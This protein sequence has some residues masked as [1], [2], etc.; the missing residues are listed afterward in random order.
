MEKRIDL[1]Q[2][3]AT[4]MSQYGEEGIIRAIF[5]EI[6]TRNKVCVEFGAFALKEVSNVYPLWFSEGWTALLLEADAKRYR[7]MVSDYEQVKSECAGRAIIVRR[8][9]STSGKDALDKILAEYDMPLDLDLLCIDV[10]GMDY[11]IWK[12]LQNF[13]PRV[14]MLEFNP[15]IP[16]DIDLVGAESGNYLGSSARAMARLG[17]E[18]G[19]GLVACTLVNAIFVREEY[20]DRFANANDLKALFDP[21]CISYAMQSFDGGVFFSG[22][23]FPFRCDPF[24]S[25]SRRIGSSS[26]PVRAMPNMA[27][28]WARHWLK[29]VK[30]MVV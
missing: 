25:E 13:R 6:G 2:C 19:Y 16:P 5:H 23:S 20:C 17:L 9:V 29:M 28:A 24:S 27:W 7:K 22:D 26:V 12:S 14:V 18:K 30:Q 21:S 3:K 4:T 1:G 10:D 11:H 15:T 8:F